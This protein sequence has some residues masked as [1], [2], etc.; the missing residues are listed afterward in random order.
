MS[1]VQSIVEKVEN[2]PPEKQQEVLNFLEL[3]QSKIDRETTPPQ[4]DETAE[5][6]LTKA[7]QF[8]GCV[9]GAADLSTNKNYLE[10]Y[11]R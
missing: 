3:L 2:L 5:S 10:E 4:E 6:V 7:A 1:L 11:G 9:E 8:M